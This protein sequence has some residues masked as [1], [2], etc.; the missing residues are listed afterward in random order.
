[1]RQVSACVAS[2]IMQ[3]GWI[4]SVEEA[5]L[6]GCILWAQ[7][8]R[9]R[10][11]PLWPHCAQAWSCWPSAWTRSVSRPAVVGGEGAV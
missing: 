1:M 9:A 6:H 10:L 3:V 5:G 8:E 2:L 11:T 4:A 7:R